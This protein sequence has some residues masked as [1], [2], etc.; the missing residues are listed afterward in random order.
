MRMKLNQAFSLLK[1]MIAKNKLL[2]V[3]LTIIIFCSFI[4]G[5][6]L[7]LIHNSTIKNLGFLPPSATGT[8][9]NSSTTCIEP[10]GGCGN[11][12]YWDSSS[13]SCKPK[14][15]STATPSC[16]PPSAGCSSSVRR[17]QSGGMAHCGIARGS[18]SR[19]F[20]RR[21]R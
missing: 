17:R 11:N 3:F 18:S 12:Y 19:V 2:A 10:S 6:Q 13:C 4:L 8:V 14:P 20:S 21:C 15:T 5:N 9:L 7:L 1:S 16:Q